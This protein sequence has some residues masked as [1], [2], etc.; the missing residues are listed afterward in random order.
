MLSHQTQKGLEITAR[1]LTELVIFLLHHGAPF[2]LTAHFNHDP[3]EQ[4][5]GKVHQSG[6]AW[7]NP[8][9][10]DLNYRITQLRVIG[11]QALA[12]KHGNTKRKHHHNVIDNTPLPRL[13]RQ[14]H[15]LTSL[16]LPK[17]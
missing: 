7:D 3:I 6:G 2:V 15:L 16:L 9:V 12:P 11:S 4:E 13:K 8:T 10:Y 1:S 17:L 14:R 5:F